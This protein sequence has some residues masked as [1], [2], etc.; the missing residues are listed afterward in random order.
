MQYAVT[1]E[2]HADARRPGHGMTRNS[3]VLHRHAWLHRHWRGDAHAL[4]D[5]GVEPG[6]IVVQCCN[7]RRSPETVVPAAA[8]PLT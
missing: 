1:V 2:L 5:H 6:K 4:L 3:R 7:I 8:E